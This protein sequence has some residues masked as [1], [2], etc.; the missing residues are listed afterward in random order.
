MVRGEIEPRWVHRDDQVSAFH[1]VNPQAPIHIL[2]IPNK[3]IA[4]LNDLA[5]EDGE[6]MG[7]LFAVCRDL[8]RQLGIAEEGYRTV[9]NCNGNGGQ[10]V[11]HIH[12]HLLAG[13]Q[14]LWPPG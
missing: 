4:T 10:S 8:A 12:L 2:I 9:F 3:H 1:D 6:L 11:Y 7:H 14:M 13:R 5:P